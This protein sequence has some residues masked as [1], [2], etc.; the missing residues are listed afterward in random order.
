MEYIALFTSAFLAATVLPFASELPLA[1][2]VARTGELTWPITVATAG[3][4]LG[5]CTTYLL[6]RAAGSRIA[7]GEATQAGRGMRLL[8]RYG[9]PALLFSWVPVIGD[10]IVV[11]AG[12]SRIPF[13]R[14]SCWTIAGKAARYFAVAWAAGVL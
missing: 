2:L 6:A 12:A 7:A 11:L 4:Y 13:G 5:A 10:G 8:Q 3:N 14:F 1:I 9:S